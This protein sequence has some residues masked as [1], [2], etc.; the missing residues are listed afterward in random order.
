MKLFQPTRPRGARRAIRARGSLE[1]IVS[2]HAPTRGATDRLEVSIVDWAVS[3]HAPT[4]GATC[5]AGYSTA[6]PAPFQPTRPRGARPAWPSP[7]TACCIAFQPTRP[8]GA[9]QRQLARHFGDD[10][11]S[12]HAPTRGATARAKPFASGRK[13]FNPRAH[14]GRD[15]HM[16][17]PLQLP[18]AVSTHAPTRGATCSVTGTMLMRCRFQPTR[19][20]GARLSAR[21]SVAAAHMFQPTRPRGAR[22]GSSR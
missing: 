15:P 6:S 12:T 4:R 1:R 18:Q 10:H 16:A 7:S 21:T 5:R 8:R 9:R 19:P 13:S 17:V 22:P 11:V 20:R 14:A 2:T 3:T